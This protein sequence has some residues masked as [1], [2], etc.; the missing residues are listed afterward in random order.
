MRDSDEIVLAPASLYDAGL[1]ANLIELY[2]HDLSEVFPIEIGPGGRFDGPGDR[3][4]GPGGRF[5][6]RG[7]RRR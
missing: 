2:V 7:G 5:N 1:L 4:G 3:F 6:G